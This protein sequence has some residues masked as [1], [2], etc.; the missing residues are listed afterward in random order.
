MGAEM[1]RL[2]G[3][4]ANPRA[5]PREA[6]VRVAEVLRAGGF[7]AYL[8]G[9]CVRDRLLGREPKDYDVATNARPEEVGGLFYRTQAVGAAFGVMLVRLLGRTVEVTTF[10]GDGTYSD[11][12]RPDRVVFADAETD[13]RRRDFTINGLFEDPVT[14]AIIDFVGGRKD[15]ENKVLRAIGDPGARLR[16]DRLRMLRAVRF[17][18][19]FGFF[20]EKETERAIREGAMD[21]KG[22]SR[23]RIGQEMKWMLSEST[24]ATACELLQNFGLDAAVL[25]E[26][27]RRVRVVRTAGLEAQV[28]Y[29][30]VLAA[31]WCD[32]RDGEGEAWTAR[33]AARAWGKALMLSGADEA[34]MGGTLAILHELERSWGDLSVSG[35]KR[36]A[37]RRWFAEGLA[38]LGVVRPEEVERIQGDVQALAETGLSPQP[39][40]NGDDL[41]AIGFEPGPI[42]REILENVYDAQLEGRVRDRREALAFAATLGGSGFSSRDEG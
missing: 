22:I 16:E 38:I 10:R 28:E 31:W 26:D 32:R 3:N 8:A 9:G 30:A 4:S 42:F 23:E 13:A 14:G 41:V 27:S 25:G 21:L 37:S 1:D 15:L 19:R 24:R 36:L 40:V 11:A 12:R 39:Y 7:V 6:A 29:P 5:T 2:Q 18:A 35:R 33:S 34:G 17:A 20:I